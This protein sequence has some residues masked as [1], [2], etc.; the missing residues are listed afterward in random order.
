[1]NRPIRRGISCVVPV[2]PPSPPVTVTVDGRRLAVYV[3]ARILAGRV[4]A[5]LSLV[6][7][8]VDRMWLEDRVLVAERAGRTVRV[9]FA[10]RF[11]GDVDVSSV[12]VAPLL[13]A[14][15]DE[16]LYQPESRTLDVRTPPVAPIVSARPG[17]GA[18]PPRPVFTPE[19]VPTP[20]PVWS[21]TPMPRRTGLP[22]P[23]RG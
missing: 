3:R 9:P 1:M 23:P 18:P 21:G 17:A 5:P 22:A 16:L 2:F 10:L 15:G 19:P 14:L 20:R 13:R 12:A 11:D 7:L 4:Y 8:L 6:R